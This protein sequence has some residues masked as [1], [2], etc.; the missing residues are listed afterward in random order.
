VINV[1][2]EK[3][4]SIPDRSNYI[5][6]FLRM[7]LIE[8]L[9][10][11]CSCMAYWKNSKLNW[12]YCGLLLKWIMIFVCRLCRGHRRLCRCLMKILVNLGLSYVFIL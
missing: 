2:P 8:L 6:I 9:S 5:Y 1:Q 3:A 12:K 4:I 10:I 7:C 11:L